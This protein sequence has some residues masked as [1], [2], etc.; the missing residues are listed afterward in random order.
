MLNTPS[1]PPPAWDEPLLALSV[2]LPLGTAHFAESASYCHRTELR[3]LVGEIMS[4]SQLPAARHYPVA[5]RVDPSS[6]GELSPRAH[7]SAGLY[8]AHCGGLAAQRTCVPA[9]RP[10]IGHRIMS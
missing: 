8:T 10:C 7:T 2:Q 3:L 1:M 4:S 5:R 9:A 6:G